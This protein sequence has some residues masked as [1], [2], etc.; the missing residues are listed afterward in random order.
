M[1]AYFRLTLKTCAW[2]AWYN[3]RHME[4]KEAERDENPTS[5]NSSATEAE[6]NGF[7]EN[8]Y[9]FRAKLSARDSINMQRKV[10]WMTGRMLRTY[11]ICRLYCWAYFTKTRNESRNRIA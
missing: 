3:V 11:L 2:A 6:T 1:I 10:Y 9:G 8:W 5:Q 4:L 7:G